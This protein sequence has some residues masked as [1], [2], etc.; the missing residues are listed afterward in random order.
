MAISISVAI[1]A[2]MAQVGFSGPTNYPVG[3]A[4]VA[5]AI[6]DFN[7]DSKL[8]LAVAYSGDFR[9]GNGGLSILLG[10]GD[11][12]FQSA[13]NIALG[14]NA[15]SIVAG[16][17][18][19]DGIVDLVVV[20]S[21][22]QDISV[23]SRAVI[24]LGNG[25]G[26]FQAAVDLNVNSF[27]VAAAAADV[28]S[29]GKMDLLMVNSGDLGSGSTLASVGVLRG[30]A[31][32]TFKTEVDYSLGTKLVFTSPIAVADFSGD[33]ELDLAVGGNGIVLLL[34]GNGDGTFQP[35]VS[36][37]FSLSSF[38]IGVH[39]VIAADFNGDGKKDLAA[40]S[41]TLFTN[42]DILN[43]QIGQGD[44]TFKPIANHS[45][46][47]P[48][49]QC[50]LAVADFDDDGKPDLALAAGTGGG[51]SLMLGNGDGTFLAP[52][53]FGAGM[54][55][56][57]LAVGDLNHDTLPDL[58]LTNFGDNTVSVL[59]N[60][61]IAGGFTLAI[62]EAGGGNGRVTS[63]PAGINCGSL[64]SESL[65]AGTT[66]TLTA[67]AE[68]G[69]SFAGWS[70]A[71]CT[72][73]GTCTVTM[74][75]NLSVTANFVLGATLS[76]TVAGTGSGSITS[77]SGGINC[78]NTGGSCSQLFAK[79][80]SV[81]LRATASGNSVF[82]GWSGACTGA[83]PNACSITLNS[84]QAVTA[85]FNPPP[86]FTLSPASQNL[87]LK[88]G[89]Q[90]SD[91]LTVG[92]QGGFSGSVGLTCSV[93]GPSPT[94]TCGISP[95]TVTPGTNATLTVSAAAF[96]AAVTSRSFERTGTLFAT[97]LPLGLMS[98]AL[99]TCFNNKRR[100]PW[101]LYLLMPVA[102]ILP[103]ACGGTSSAPP[104]QNYTV[105]VTAMSGAI[106]HSTTVSVT[107][108]K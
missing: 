31:N 108:I 14:S 18:N 105:T 99:T 70:G 6:A 38:G 58:V 82:A 25:D 52:L 100:R 86:D 66:V 36:S 101:A 73:A 43:V 57:S 32:G 13:K 87:T 96:T 103:A 50:Q 106:Q 5:I 102:M 60:T 26:T 75:S 98:L 92:T 95:A 97:V 41:T 47:F 7:G 83:D 24:L 17:F 9:A 61:T 78:T 89:S 29:D 79:G 88:L 4:P 63:S 77:S 30:N 48:G 59:L 72:G 80:T 71:G 33:G 90:A 37:G 91:V 20:S 94:P 104:A 64:C 19:Q 1:P 28:D 27:A 16:D 42:H 107:L 51:V 40:R 65:A 76:V 8:D 69:S 67:I 15:Q 12:T 55:T 53:H 45:T 56:C 84:D 46:G 34:R 44:G 54:G 10:N 49:S 22:E 11:G 23:P 2:A 35:A 85:T 62:A 3:T 93:G 81:L 68:A 21:G 74:N 39:S